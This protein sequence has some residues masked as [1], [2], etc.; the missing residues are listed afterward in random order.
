M[1]LGTNQ[2]CSTY[3]SNGLQGRVEQTRTGEGGR[4]TREVETHEQQ[5]REGRCTKTKTLDAL[6]LHLCTGSFTDNSV[7]TFVLSII[8]T[9]FSVAL[10]P[11]LLT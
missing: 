1:V 10:L 2:A 9:H 4:G 7:T 8:E 3:P 5:Q 11:F 6:R